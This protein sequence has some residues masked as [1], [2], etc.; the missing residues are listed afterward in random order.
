MPLDE[1]RQ[2]NLTNW[3]ERTGIH[4]RSR[5]YDLQGYVA[6]PNKISRI[7]QFDMPDLGD[8]AGKTLL[9]L[10]CHIGTD[11]L[12]LARLGANVTGVDFSPEAIVAAR[13]LSADSGTPGRFEV[14][15]LY[16]VPQVIAETFDVVYTGVGAIGWLPDIVGW[17]R[18]VA[19]MLRPGGPFFVRDF[20]PELWTVDGERDD[21]ELVI[22]YPYFEGPPKRFENEFT[23]SDGERLSNSVNYE[24][25]HGL[26]EI[27]MALL[28]NGLSLQLL[29]EHTFSESK[30]I[31]SM[32]KGED[33]R[34]RLPLGPERLPLMFTIRAVKTAS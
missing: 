12:S 28:D 34:W 21:G 4:V 17:G 5:L 2:T 7:V 3:N 25:N 10:Q 23:Y 11:T 33:D 19:A 6:D 32:V 14:A 13:K 22:K 1:F 30:N 9:H 20:H 16:D 31:D 24:W 8:V 18:V 27:V 29:K 15:E 26:G